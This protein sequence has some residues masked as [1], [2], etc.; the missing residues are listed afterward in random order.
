MYNRYVPQDDGSFRCNRQQDP[1]PPTQPAAPPTPHPPK[2]T[3][4]GQFF[5]NL[6][7][8]DLDTGD[9]LVII[10]LLLIAGDSPSRQNS[11]MLTLALYLFL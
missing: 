8:A 2:E 4:A 11:A 1:T 3:S 10:L 7:P 9:L 6:I 5:R